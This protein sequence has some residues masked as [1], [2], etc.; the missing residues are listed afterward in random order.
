M[1]LGQIVAFILIACAGAA[2]YLAINCFKPEYR[3]FSGNIILGVI[4]I[5]S[6]LW[7]FGF[8]LV[9]VQSN[10]HVAYIGRTVGMIGVI[11]FIIFI[12]LL[13]GYVGDVPEWMRK[14]A[15]FFSF[16][17]VPIYFLTV[18]PGAVEFTYEATGMSY[19]FKPG[20][21]NT[22]Y[23]LYTV[24]IALNIAVILTA[25]LKRA[26]NHREKKTGIKLFIALIVI[27]IGLVMDTVFP[28]IGLRAIPGSSLAQFFCV[29]IVFHAI[30]DYNRT[31]LIPM[32]MF[33]Y[34]YRS[35]AAPVLVFDNE[36][37]LAL[38]NE[39]AKE[40]FPHAKDQ[41][42]EVPS[43]WEE[44]FEASFDVKENEITHLL[45]RCVAKERSLP[46]EVDINR[47]RD[48]Y[49]DGLGYI[50]TVKDMTEI[51]QAMNSLREAKQAAEEANRAKSVF[52]AN[53]SHE[54]RTPLNAIV[55]FSE[56]LIAEN[57]DKNNLE[58][59]DDIR[60]SAHNLLAIINDILDISKV[61]SG[62]AELVETKYRLSEVLRDTYLI[63]ST[64]TEKKGL[65]FVM[66]IEE[67]IPDKLIGDA[68][69]VRGVLVN[70]MNNAVKY[71]P[72]GYVKITGS[73]AKRIDDD[74][75]L[76]FVIK[77][78]GIGIKKEDLPKVYDSFAQVD[79]KVNRGIEGTGLGL[80]IVKAYVELMGGSI[81]IESE[82]GKGSSFILTFHQKVV[83]R[84]SVVGKF[85][86]GAP[87]GR[88]ASNIGEVHF[89]GIRVLSV[90]DTKLNLKLVEKTLAKYG[91][92]VT[93]VLSG[94]EA[95]DMC[96]AN[97]YDVI[98]MDQMMPEM[99]GVEAMRRIRSLSDYY[100]E[101]GKCLIIALTANAVAG[102]KEE[103][104][105]LGFD[106]Y[107][108]KP[109]NFHTLEGMFKKYISKGRLHV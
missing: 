62:K 88:M 67:T 24:I 48:K 27:A 99:D 65:S 78:T 37:R 94:E 19:I 10:P 33:S 53:M 82:Y 44:M 34:V 83:D 41:R 3:S 46:V 2:V 70:V 31:R 71:T 56:L 38:V 109:M 36:W 52:L 18:S 43:L 13:I 29:L 77:D 105:S 28:L 16:L 89:D 60:V 49:Q 95:I 7:G 98:L 15:L 93:S 64:L 21:A 51:E 40:M 75:T 107:L 58:H 57:T 50:V 22:I 54:I 8:G 25:L 9:F 92:L 5:M 84:S 86:E 90:D 11:G 104:I 103:L 73:V 39:A 101:N 20:P 102:V 63:G 100:A 14:V 17:G 1:T 87:S 106:D 12:Q 80:A 81:E 69:K 4:C 74:L 61:E 26:R 79:K 47:I 30:A 32:N 59:I 42:A 96:R 55:G 35:V 66:D 91:M 68:V 45:E 72:S 97:E 76:R 6:A 23:T 85:G 108:A